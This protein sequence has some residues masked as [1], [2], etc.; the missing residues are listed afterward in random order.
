MKHKCRYCDYESAY[1]PN[2]RRHEY[3]KHG[4][5]AQSYPQPH[6]EQVIQQQQP[7]Y[8][9]EIPP[10]PHTQISPQQNALVVRNQYL[11]NKVNELQ[12]FIRNQNV[13]TGRKRFRS[14][15]EDDDET[16][17]ETDEPDFLSESDSEESDID[18]GQE[19]ED[20]ITD[21]NISF[22]NIVS[23]RK[24]YLQALEKYNEIED[25]DKQIFSKSI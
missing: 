1:K 9:R 18:V 20:I 11:Q 21:I 23:L 3:K 8:Q 22:T 25:E 10:P 4:E 15:N 19:L 17:M 2:V 6:H 14:N 5:P 7:I 12:T 24:Q 16:L 13:Q